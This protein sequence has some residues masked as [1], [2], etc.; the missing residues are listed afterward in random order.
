MLSSVNS[1][2]LAGISGRIIQVECETSN[3]L[4]G[5]TIVGLGSKSVDE[6]KERVRSAFTQSGLEVPRKRIIINLA[7][8]DVPKDGAS[9]DLPMALSILLKSGQ[10]P[11]KCLKGSV[12]VGELGLDGSVRSVRGIIG[13]VMAAKQA[14]FSRIYLPAD[15]VA[16]A[17][18]VED[19][20]VYSVSNVKQLYNHL[21]DRL[22][23]QPAI[24]SELKS[25]L[26]HVIDLCDIQQQHSAKR[27]LIIAA[28]GGHNLVMKG[29]PG[30]GKTMLAKAFIS[31]LPSLN[32]DQVLEVTQLHSLSVRKTEVIS[33]P[34]LRQPHHTASHTAVLGGGRP[35]LPGE[36]SLAHHGVLFLDEL[37]EFNRLSLEG[38]RQPLEDNQITIARAEQTVTYPAN[39]ILIAT[40]NPCPCGYYGDDERECTCLPYQ[41]LNYEKKLSG[42]LLDRFDMAIEVPRVKSSLVLRAKT[43]DKI[44]SQTAAELV[45]TARQ[46]QYRRHNTTKLNSELTN[47]QLHK[48]SNISAEAKELLAIAGEK[49]LISPRG[50]I[51]SLRV[52][53][54]IADIDSSANI[55]KCHVAEAL[56]YRH[57]QADEVLKGVKINS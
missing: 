47:P 18:L 55:E 21:T 43:D 50:L 49:L 54:T 16:Q 38:L 42:P 53:R 8:A 1:T 7:P 2:A 44:T 4:P 46:L 27:A 45:S 5:I 17:T 41:R 34:P 10:I 30:T 51:R 32:K 19:I 26:T 29:P 9:F 56:Q 15:N 33:T 3:S 24:P 40:Q 22:P 6:S 48:F 13:H 12:A 25:K 28:G 14:G 57:S 20:E 37:P 31:I 11:D 23:L 35:P 39:F 52:A 36:V